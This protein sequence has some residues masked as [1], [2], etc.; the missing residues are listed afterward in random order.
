MLYLKRDA[1][2]PIFPIALRDFNPLQLDLELTHRWTS[3][4]AG[5][6]VVLCAAACPTAI[7]VEHKCGN[8]NRFSPQPLP[9]FLCRNPPIA[10]FDTDHMTTSYEVS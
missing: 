7:C 2:L 3:T 6:S 8:R 4:R 1:N 9:G 10:P 5:V